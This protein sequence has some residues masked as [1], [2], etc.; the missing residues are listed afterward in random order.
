MKKGPR[1]GPW[2]DDGRTY[3]TMR[4]ERRRKPRFLVVSFTALISGVFSPVWALN[5]S[6]LELMAPPWTTR[7]PASVSWLLRE[8]K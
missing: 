5:S 8:L 7:S 2:F 4:Q 1:R 6:F 3:R